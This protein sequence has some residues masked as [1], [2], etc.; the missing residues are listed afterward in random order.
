MKL[1]TRRIALALA[2]ITLLTVSGQAT[3][4][5]L[6]RST[7]KT[8]FASRPTSNVD[9]VSKK[10]NFDELSASAIQK[11]LISKGYCDKGNKMA[12]SAIGKKNSLGE[13]FFTPGLFAVCMF[14]D[15]FE[16]RKNLE[17]D[18]AELSLGPG[19]LVI[20]K[21]KAARQFGSVR[22]SSMIWDVIGRDW[23]IQFHSDEPAYPGS[24]VYAKGKMLKLSK[25]V[26]GANIALNYQPRD[27]CWTLVKMTDA[28][29]EYW[30][31]DY[32]QCDKYLPFLLR[33]DTRPIWTKP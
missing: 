17:P 9:M 18:A 19:Y 25:A 14:P 22:R 6:S 23:Q 33:Y 4:N 8:H 7:V 13:D 12:A 16:I 29:G 1:A 32:E 5:D 2:P 28:K 26:S 27:S 11:W 20:L 30:A 15:R 24:F 10:V 3:A 21:G 31:D